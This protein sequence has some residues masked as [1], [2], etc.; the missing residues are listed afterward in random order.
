MVRGDRIGNWP[1]KAMK[2][3][4]YCGA[5]Y[6]DNLINCP[7]D[8][9][10]LVGQPVA[11]E[12]KS[13]KYDIPP[14]PVQGMEDWVTILIP[15]SSFEAHLVF[16]RLKVSGIRVR[17][18]RSVI[19]GAIYTDTMTFVQVHVADYDVARELLNAGNDVGE[20]S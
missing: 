5:E 14:L 16:N 15:H 1:L 7:I 12:S 20:A 18:N 2:H 17:V 11:S 4:S 3:C 8:H 13:D 6:P 10:S 9:E 19:G